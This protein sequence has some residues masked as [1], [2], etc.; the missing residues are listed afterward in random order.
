[1][2]IGAWHVG[3]NPAGDVATIISSQGWNDMYEYIFTE[4]PNFT[5]HPAC[6]V[7]SVLCIIPVTWFSNLSVN[8][9]ELP[10]DL[11]LDG[12]FLQR[13]PG[14][15]YPFIYDCLYSHTYTP[16]FI[17]RDL[18]SLKSILKPTIEA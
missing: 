10:L 14:E 11:I 2:L 8:L 7:A 5:C 6:T 16:G 3:G 12:P 18:K 4:I 17:R 1:M 15:C 9:D 13:L